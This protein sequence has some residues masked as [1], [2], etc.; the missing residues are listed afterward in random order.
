MCFFIVRGSSELCRCGDHGA[1]NRRL[2]SG[3]RRKSRARLHV[4][5]QRSKFQVEKKGDDG[6]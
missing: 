6:F 3:R 2:E 5:V 4:G 1:R